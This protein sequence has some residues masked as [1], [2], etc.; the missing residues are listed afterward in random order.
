VFGQDFHRQLQAL[1]EMLFD[2]GLVQNIEV[3]A[4]LLP[5]IDR[6]GAAYAAL[7]DGRVT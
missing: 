7:T 4:C 1:F 2:I 5:E 3:H 6:F